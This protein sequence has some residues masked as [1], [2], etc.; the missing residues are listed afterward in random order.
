[1]QQIGYPY[2]SP[3]AYKPLKPTAKKQHI[4]APFNLQFILVSDLEGQTRP[5][6]KKLFL[7][8]ARKFGVLTHARLM[9]FCP[10]PDPLAQNP[11]PAPNHAPG[12]DSA[13]GQRGGDDSCQAPRPAGGRR[14]MEQGCLGWP[15]G[16]C[17]TTP[18]HTQVLM[19]LLCS[20]YIQGQMPQL[21]AMEQH[22][23]SS[24]ENRR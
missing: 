19:Q 3:I 9:Q 15:L 18:R 21:R 2:S 10:V 5:G 14:R 24:A 7:R 4:S 8:L 6:G 22:L 23:F 1:M 17:P 16:R 12:G 20:R 11:F 13:W